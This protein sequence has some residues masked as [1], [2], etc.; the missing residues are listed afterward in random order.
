MTAPSITVI[1]NPTA[2]G[3]AARRTA[4]RAVSRLQARGARVT[5][6]SG[7]DVD[8]T[9]AALRRARADRP[10][11]VVTV[12]GDGT[13]RLGIEALQESGIPLVLV[14]VGTGNDLAL[15]LGIPRDPEHAADVAVDGR[16]ATLDVVR[17]TREHGSTDL[18]G[19]VFASGF[20][21]KV[22]ERANR[23]RWPQG[24]ARYNIAIAVEFF[25][26]KALPY[27]LTWTDAEGHDGSYDGSLLLT[28]VGNTS[29]YGGGVPICPTADPTDGILELTIIR[30]ASRW[31]LIGVL[32]KAFSGTHVHEPE[33]ETHR[34]RSIR[35]ASP[36]LTGYADGDPMGALP[37]Q[38]DV[39]PGALTM[40]LPAV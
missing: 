27:R 17:L 37:A 21:S 40:R 15:S 6:F 2:G 1:V 5:V 20:D 7:T 4:Q 26:L 28:A 23:M 34:V 16:L 29:S 18:F 8:D 30:P 38:L 33:V 13:A 39:V 12:G 9:R 19:S 10:D 24:R 36:G 11:A 3:G 31:R 14:P 32:M 25:L 22:N 35:I